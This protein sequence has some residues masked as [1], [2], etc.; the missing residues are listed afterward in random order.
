VYIFHSSRSA[1]TEVIDAD[2]DTD[3]PGAARS[4][5][6]RID[7]VVPRSLLGRERT[8]YEWIGVVEPSRLA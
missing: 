2:T 4:E 8:D 1:G 3:S 5:Y 7:S 6:V